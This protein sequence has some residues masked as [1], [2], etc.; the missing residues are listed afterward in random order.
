M[1]WET[2]L[3]SGVI[4]AI[5]AGIIEL[6]KLNNSNK[7]TFVI[8]QREEWRE[9][10]REIATDID[11]AN[12]YSISR[13]L[14]E[15]K[16]R[17]NAYGNKEFPAFQNDPQKLYEYYM[18]DGHIHTV[19]DKL[20]QKE[21]FET[22]KKKLV[23]YLS[24]LLKFDWERSKQEAIFNKTYVI[25][26]FFE[27]VGIALLLLSIP[28]LDVS[29]IAIIVLMCF[30][31]FSPMISTMLFEDV[32]NVILEN[33]Q[34]KSFF[35]S[36]I[37]NVILILASLLNDNTVVLISAIFM[38]LASLISMIVIFKNIRIKKDYI[39]SLKEYD[40]IEFDSIQNKLK[41]KLKKDIVLI[42]SVFF[43]IFE[44]ILFIGE[45][46]ITIPSFFKFLRHMLREFRKKEQE[47]NIEIIEQDTK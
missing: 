28:Q 46:I 22:N 29:F 41:E 8:K 15:L 20:E 10:I 26:I 35:I 21:E 25:S 38:L 44:F 7:A 23:C 42:N 43:L 31:Y 19:I 24:N 39:N 18:K 9:K 40:K 27:I 17:I 34:I 2:I 13:H 5:V 4:A 1:D 33:F 37:L 47:K 45:F 11:Q 16:T 14:V 6:F 36:N 3:T 30:L 12:T 32:E